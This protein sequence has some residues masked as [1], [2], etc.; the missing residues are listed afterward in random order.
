MPQ[1]TIE[2]SANLVGAC[3]FKALALE[4]HQLVVATI[5]TELISCKTRLVCHDNTVIADG[6]DDHAMIHL[7][8]RI[9]SGR[10][11]AEKKR[12]GEQVHAAARAALDAPEGLRIQITAE[13]RELDRE[14][15]HK[16]RL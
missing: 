12:L 16:L 11:E 7:D 5:D 3:D 4:V 9:L 2:Y 13:V 14:N 15:Y 10:P 1:I 6:A 8:L